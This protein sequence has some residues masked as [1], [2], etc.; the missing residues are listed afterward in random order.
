M[1][2][3]EIQRPTANLE[4]VYDLLHMLGRCRSSLPF[5]ATAPQC[6]GHEKERGTGHVECGAPCGGSSMAALEKDVRESCS[7]MPHG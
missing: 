1:Y 5:N 3:C 6:E 7:G 4:Q 2:V